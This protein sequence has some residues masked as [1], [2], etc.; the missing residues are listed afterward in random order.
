M[1]EYKFEEDVNSATMATLEELLHQ[2]CTVD[3]SSYFGE[4]VPAGRVTRLAEAAARGDGHLIICGNYLKADQ[5]I[6]LGTAAGKHL[7]V[8]FGN[9]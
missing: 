8:A 7:T 4:V 5:L 6:S 1:N 2:G 3:L 9:R